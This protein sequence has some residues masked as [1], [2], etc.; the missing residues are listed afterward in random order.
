MVC[1]TLSNGSKKKILPNSVNKGKLM[2]F[3]NFFAG[4][5]ADMAKK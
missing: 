1:V 2:E 5:S 3:G 4:F